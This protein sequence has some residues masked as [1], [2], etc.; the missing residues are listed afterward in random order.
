MNVDIGTKAAQF[1]RKEIHKWIFLAVR[2]LKK[3]NSKKQREKN[4]GE[5][6]I[7]MLVTHFFVHKYKIFLK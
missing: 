1:L 6:I 3:K 5:K 2:Y 4:Q 7:K